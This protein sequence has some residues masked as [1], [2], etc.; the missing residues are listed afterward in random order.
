MK[1]LS[2]NAVMAIKALMN[3]SFK[4]VN[5]KYE[6]LTALER[7][8]VDKETFEELVAWAKIDE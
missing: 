8:L 3:Y 1:D 5:Y 7:K 4:P 2:E 6:D